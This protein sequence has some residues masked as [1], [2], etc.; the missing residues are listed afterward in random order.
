MEFSGLITKFRVNRPLTDQERAHR[1]KQQQRLNVEPHYQLSVIQ[2]NSTYLESVDKWFGWKGTLTAIASIIFLIFVGTF[3]AIS[4]IW[5]AKAAGYGT[6]PP[7]A[8]FWLANGLGMAA[9]AAF[10]GMFSVWLIRKESFAFT[11]YPIRFNRA[12]RMV[13]V[14][15]TDGSILSA[16]WDEVFFTLGH[17][18]QWNEWEIRGHILAPDKTTVRESF[19]LSYL[20]S[21]SPSDAEPGRKHFSPDD[22]VH[23][24]W[25]FIR[26]Y[27]ED[28]P[29]AVAGQVAFCMPIATRRESVRVG[30]ERVFA[31]MAGAPFLIFWLMVPFC[32]LV[33]LF[34]ILAMRTSKVPRWSGEI[35]AACAIEKDDQYAIIGNAAGNSIPLFPD[36]AHAADTGSMAPDLKLEVGSCQQRC[37]VLSCCFS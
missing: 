6:P 11:H 7:D 30:T 9:V 12:T 20:G 28:G 21:L 27:M 36:A 31:N 15:R 1:L 22:F 35:E 24:H 25:E 18:V 32:A 14:F 29:A 19:A 33:S 26:R 16:P 17:M 37:R 13:H 23:A 5:L 4:I 3:G 2:L 34:R 8:G 10:A